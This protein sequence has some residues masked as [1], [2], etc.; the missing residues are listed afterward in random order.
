[1]INDDE[2][3]KDILK[4]FGSPTDLDLGQFQKV[5]TEICDAKTLVPMTKEFAKAFMFYTK[6]VE[7]DSNEENENA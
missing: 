5:V 1:M 2:I 4:S 7:K 3:C 6:K